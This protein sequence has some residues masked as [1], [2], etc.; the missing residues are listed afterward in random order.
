MPLVSRWLE[1]DLGRVVRNSSYL[2]CVH[3]GNYVVPLVVLFYLVKILGVE[4]FGVYAICAAVAAYVQVIIDY[5][6]SL[7]GCRAVAQNKGDLRFVSGVFWEVLLSKLLVASL[8]LLVCVLCFWLIGLD[9]NIFLPAVLSAVF[10]SLTPVWFFQG[11]ES[12]RGVTFFNVTGK[13]LSCIPVVLL[14]KGPGDL[15]VV[16]YSQAF[17]AF[18]VMLVVY[19]HTFQAGLVLKLPLADLNVG[20]QLREGW[21][22]F[23][24]TLSSMVIT[25]GGTLWLGANYPSSVVGVYASVERIV[26]A[27]S[28]LFVPLSQAIYPINS[29]AFGAGVK[30]G[31]RSVLLTGG[32]F[33][34]VGVFVALAFLLSYSFFLDFFNYPEQSFTYFKLFSA[35][36]VMGVINNVLGTQ[37]L[38]AGGHPRVYAKCFY[39][40]ALVF[41]AAAYVMIGAYAGLGAVYSLLVAEAVLSML[42]LLSSVMVFRR[43]GFR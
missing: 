40:T 13:V 3:G 7:T 16:F 1:S 4:S 8:V 19:F 12:F 11:L 10:V 33:T 21:H 37:L 2:L 9:Q 35:W 29:R 6:F 20:R 30:V 23:S 36:I 28:S 42:L 18:L 22:I 43:E 15:Y 34:T 38:T 32:A 39:V 14:V 27:V 17:F 25:N 24:A 5:G 41:V 31:L 26:K